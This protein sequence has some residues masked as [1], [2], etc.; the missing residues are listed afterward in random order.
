MNVQKIVRDIQNLKIQGAVNV[1]LSALEIFQYT[2]ETSKSENKSQFKK[3]LESI[4]NKLFSTRSTEPMMRNA[5]RFAMNINF[6]RYELRDL[7]DLI[8][9]R[10][11]EFRKMELTSRKRIVEIGVKRI[12]PR[13]TIM[14]HCHSSTVTNILKAAKDKNIKVICT[15]TRPRFQ[16]RITTKELISA[17][18]PTTMIVDSAARHYVNEVDMVLVGADVINN[19]G[20]IINK[21]GTGNIALCANEARTD[22]YCA[23][24]IMKFDPETVFGPEEEIEFRP[25]SEV[26]KNPP[27]KLRILNP[28]F[29][30]VPREYIE[31][32]ITESGIF[33]PGSIYDVVKREYNWIFGNKKE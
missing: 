7:K 24:T 12:E 9:S 33:A 3:E 17:G 13:S 18:I 28:A 1:A 30:E 19:D 15:E 29:D 5:L 31:G 4:K 11:E 21:I 23:T 25:A 10:C 8:T 6:E 32:I 20:S 14:T 2:C 26:W 22:L 27:K 16:G